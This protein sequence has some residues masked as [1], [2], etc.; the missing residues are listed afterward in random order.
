MDDNVLWKTLLGLA[1]AVIG[2]LSG[3]VVYL[4][5]WIRRLYAEAKAEAAKE[6]RERDERHERL[7]D[8]VNRIQTERERERNRG[9]SP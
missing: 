9:Q 2:A 3:A 5:A 4:I 8:V 1:T 7:L 6:V